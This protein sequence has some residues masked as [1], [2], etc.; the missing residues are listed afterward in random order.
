MER[1]RHKKDMELRYSRFCHRADYD[2]DLFQ[3]VTRAEIADMFSVSETI[4]KDWKRRWK[5][6]NTPRP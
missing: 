2:P 4:I 3:E 1:E 5:K 6:E